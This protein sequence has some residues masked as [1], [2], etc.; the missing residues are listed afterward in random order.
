MLVA[1]AHELSRLDVAEWV[2]K[3]AQAAAPD[4][5]PVDDGLQ[6]AGANGTGKAQATRVSVI[7]EDDKTDEALRRERE[8]KADAKRYD[9]LMCGMALI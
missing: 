3:N 9:Y 5:T 7:I 1:C 2:R 8:K 4:G 6:I